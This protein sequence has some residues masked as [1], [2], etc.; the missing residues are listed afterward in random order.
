MKIWVAYNVIM[1]IIL[2]FCPSHDG[3]VLSPNVKIID[4]CTV[5]TGLSW[6]SFI[7]VCALTGTQ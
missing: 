3:R 7:V 2:L 4:F 5:M 1:T 6:L